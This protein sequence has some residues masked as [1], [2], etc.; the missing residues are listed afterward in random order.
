MIN[1][2]KSNERG[3]VNHGWLQSAHTFSFGSYHDPKFMG[4]SV[5]RV[6]NEDRVVAGAGF[7]P[8]SHQNMEIVSYVIEGALEH[9]DSLGNVATMKPGDLQRMSAG[10]G[11]THS[12]YNPLKDKGCHFLQIWILPDKDGYKPSYQQ[13]NFSAGLQKG[14]VILVASNSGRDGS[15]SL[16][17]DVDLYA[18]KSP[19]AGERILNT[20][21]QRSYWVQ[22][23]SGVV[24]VNDR[25]VT[26]GDALQARNET[27]LHLKWQQNSEFLL[28]DLP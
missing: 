13:K 22:V 16:N 10:I 26:A 8:H 4:F 28:F 14:E 24:K 23:V 7:Q 25:T 18:L 1:I 12:E 9:K 3:H 6:I 20:D 17:Q 11:V 27:R 19:S 21:E 15:I 2:R 5:L